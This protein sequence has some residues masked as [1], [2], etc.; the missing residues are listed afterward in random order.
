M[1]GFVMALQ[2]F[3]QK[4]L[5]AE[6][7][8]QHEVQAVFLLN[9]TRFIRWPDAAFAADDAPMIIGLLHD[10][11]VATALGEATRH[12]M[13]GRHP[14]TVRRIHTAA[15]IDGCHLIF[16]AKADLTDAAQMLTSLRAKPVL[17]VSDADGFLPL[18]GHVQLFNRA[19]QVKL[20]L[21]LKNLK[22]AD[23]SA[24]APLLRV[25]EVIGK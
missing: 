7:P 4:L 6:S 2:F 1:I 10:D 25:A 15:D 14:I 22:R 5:A 8:P 18:G 17:T 19:G 21:D 13:A 16:F 24:S 23:L 11:P 3:P 9:L 20:R 12:E